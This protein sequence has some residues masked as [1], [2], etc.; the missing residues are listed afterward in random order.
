MAKRVI[1]IFPRF[2]RLDLIEQIRSVFDPLAAI[3][4]AH[5]TLVPP[6]EDDA[7]SE[8]LHSHIK[9]AIQNIQPFHITLQGITGHEGEYLF[10]NVKRGNDELIELRD[11]LYSGIL[12][13]HFLPQ[14]TYVPHLTVGR[15]PNSELFLKALATAQELTAT[16]ETQ[17]SEVCVYSVQSNGTRPI[18]FNVP[19]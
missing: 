19:L 3:V 10:L 17:I 15:L 7:S 8:Q 16:F 2:E 5:I 4:K 11:R 18:E 12:A 13:T 6:F 9:Q 14:Y 1:V